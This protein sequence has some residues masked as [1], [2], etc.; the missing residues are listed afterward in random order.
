MEPRPSNDLVKPSIR[1]ETY[2]FFLLS[3]LW[4]GISAQRALKDDVWELFALKEID[5]ENLLVK[6][7]GLGWIHYLRSGE[8]IELK[9]T[10]NSWRAWLDE[11]GR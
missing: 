6:A 7:Q 1:P 2:C 5:H 3:N 9:P 4:K 10:H 8:I 11:L